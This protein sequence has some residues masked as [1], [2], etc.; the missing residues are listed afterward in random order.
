MKGIYSLKQRSVSFFSLL[1]AVFALTGLGNAASMFDDPR[2]DRI[3]QN[4]LDQI[5]TQ[6]DFFAPALITIN[7]FDN[8]DMGTSQAEPHISQNPRNPLW[9]FCAYNI[10]TPFR[11]LDGGITWTPTSV[12][13][14]SS[15]GD[16]ITAYDSL[17][18]LFYDNMKSPI[19]GTWTIKSTNGGV[20]WGTGVSANVGNDKNWL[21]ADQT[22]G[23][24]SNYLYGAMTPGNIVRSTDNGAT[25]STMATFTNSLPGAMT[26][27]GANGSVQGGSVYAVM[28]TGTNSA[29][30]YTI[31][32]STNGGANFTQ[33]SQNQYSNYIGTETGGRSTVQ[34]MRT[35]PYPMIAADNSFGPYR[36][37]L[38]LVYAS[39]NP[40]GNGNKSDIFLRYSTDFGA[41]FSNAV[42]VNDDANSQNNFQFF[43]AIWCEKNTGKL[44]I[45]WYDSRRCPTSDSM[46][47]YATYTTDGGQTFATNQRVT[48]Q[49][50]KIKLSSSGSA[51]AYQ[52]DYDAISGNPVSAM[53]CWT[54]FRN[55]NYGAYTGYFPDY[56]MRVSNNNLN[57]NGNS[58]AN[59]YT[60][61]P[62][63]K[64]YD[65]VVKFSATVTPTPTVGAITVQFVGRDSITTIP[66][67][68]QTRISVAP[69]TTTG[70]YTVAILAQ[71]PNGTPRHQRTVT[72]NVG[73]TGVTETGAPVKYE[74]SQN[75][76]NPFNPTTK[77][78]YSI[79]K[80]GD[81]RIIVFDALGKQVTEMVKSNLPA[82]SYS[83]DFNG[84]RLSSGLYFYRIVTDG[85]T[86]TKKMML[87]K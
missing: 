51:P 35:R 21:C 37:R 34:G 64:L 14:P 81:V 42:V 29:G 22:G 16:P 86:D 73:S 4:Y 30:I 70:T 20:N 68:V 15:A 31:Y 85:F 2:F 8:F 54:D 69:N 7:D 41:T 71:G 33:M 50:F 55:N 11:T 67:S 3:P 10:N 17:G 52:G 28:H 77:I 53:V 80:Q 61:I 82:G 26:C 6:N 45:K 13:L 66:D 24:Y 63:T 19:T 83:V 43:P 59:I 58:F 9:N 46:D 62:A 44:Y 48:N 23:P 39:N 79:A 49:M 76:P 38:Y 1:I 40:S 56:A 12:S 84:S 72:V 18:N 32:R 60:T 65:K 36:G 47:V 5:A 78:T 25:F 87:V 75:Y 74:L 57:I 27:V